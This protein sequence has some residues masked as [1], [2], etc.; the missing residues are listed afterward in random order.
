MIVFKILKGVSFNIKLHPVNWLGR[1]LVRRIIVRMYKPYV[2][3][4]IM[5]KLIYKLRLDNLISKEVFNMLMDQHDKSK[6]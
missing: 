4:S 1:K 5:R 3:H 6:K 2:K